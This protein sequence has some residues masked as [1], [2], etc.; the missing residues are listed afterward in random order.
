MQKESTQKRLRLFSL[1]ALL[2]SISFSLIIAELIL[3]ARDWY[4]A[5][6]KGTAPQEYRNN[7][8]EFSATRHHRLIPNVRYRHKELEFDYVWANNS[9]GMRDRER[10]PR[11]DPQ[12]FRILFLGDSI[13][14]WY[15]V[16]LAQTMVSYLEESLNQPRRE[17]TIEVLNGGIFG[18]S[19]LLEYLYLLELMPLVSPNMVI[20]GFTL[21]NDVG[22]DYF[23]AQQARTNIIDG[24]LSF[25]QLKW[26]WDY[27]NEVVDGLKSKSSSVVKEESR[28]Y[29]HL[30]LFKKYIMPLL[31][32]SRIIS[33]IREL[34]DR[35]QKE[36]DYRERNKLIE[37]LKED[38]KYDIRINL[39]LVKYPVTDWKKRLE[40]WQLSQTYISKIH[41]LCQTRGVPMVLVVFPETEGN[42][43]M[44]PYEILD[45]LGT[46]L[47]IPVIQ[48]L[49]ELRALSPEKQKK[50]FYELDGHWNV[51]GNRLVA[52]IINRKL[53]SLNLL[54]PEQKY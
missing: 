53:R 38:R 54:P 16:P 26:P 31:L 5:T 39:G 7:P 9:L 2:L 4:C 27:C 6:Q 14:Q 24:S 23:Y 41:G 30:A 36:R 52:T 28:T 25:E 10:S 17:K 45:K 34:R 1:I 21:G 32:K 19:P 22:D 35:W 11:S 49:L 8:Y 51:K 33:T 20:V 47:S 50:L 12:N 48:L 18:Y 13:V 37:Q 3:R 40:Y 46:E 43:F 44:E 29:S 42:L 15:G